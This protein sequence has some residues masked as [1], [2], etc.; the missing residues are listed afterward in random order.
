[1]IYEKQSHETIIARGLEQTA[2]YRD[3]KAPYAPAYLVIFDHRAETKEKSWE[4]RL[5]WNEKDGIT[6]ITC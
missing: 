4:E 1:M 2:K 5:S 6:V 3:T